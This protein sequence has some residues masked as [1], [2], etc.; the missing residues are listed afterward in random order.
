MGGV[1]GKRVKKKAQH[2]INISTVLPIA[3][4]KNQPKDESRM[5]S[6]KN[7]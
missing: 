1:G 6:Q 3:R 2:S 7:D 5:V 4:Q